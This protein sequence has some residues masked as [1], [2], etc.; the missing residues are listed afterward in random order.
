MSSRFRIAP[1]PRG[2]AAKLSISGG[3]PKGMRENISTPAANFPHPPLFSDKKEQKPLGI[4]N[5]PLNFVSV[6]PVHRLCIN[7]EAM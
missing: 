5:N 2:I 1:N 6:A 7:T 3:I 4:P